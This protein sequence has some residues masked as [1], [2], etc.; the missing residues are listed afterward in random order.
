MTDETHTSTILLRHKTLTALPDNHEPR[1]EDIKKLTKEVRQNLKA[2]YTTCGGGAHSHL[3]LMMS[4]ADYLQ[5]T[6]V[7]FIIPIHPGM[8]PHVPANATQ[9]I[10]QEIHQRFQSDIQEF[11][12]YHKVQLMVKMQILQAIPNRYLEILEDINNEYDNVMI[13]QMMTH[14]TTTYGA[15][16]HSN[17]EENLKELDKEWDPN[18]KL[19]IFFSCQHKIQQFAAT[20]VPDK[21]LLLKAIIAIHTTRILNTDIDTF[22]K[23]LTIEQTYTNFKTDLLRQSNCRESRLS[24]S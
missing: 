17:L 10:I 5:L 21:M 6:G 15:I 13:E 19:T 12:L 9:F 2:I 18:T 1:A 22:K 16:S 3:A 4:A 23:H 7:P 11:N 8:A 24:H 14:L 20:P